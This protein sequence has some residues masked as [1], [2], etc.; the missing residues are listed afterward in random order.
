[1]T[2]S[3]HNRWGQLAENIRFETRAF[4]RGDY[5]Q[6][7]SKNVFQTKNPATRTELAVFPDSD[8]DTI[9]RAVAAARD[10]FQQWRHLA[11]EQRKSLLLTVANQIET[12]RETLALLDCLEMGMPISM[13]L[14][15]VE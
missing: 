6:A 13:A 15:Q 8:A 2:P 11:P 4:I 3:S 9:D 14:E 12:E 10:A 5:C 7:T 1:M